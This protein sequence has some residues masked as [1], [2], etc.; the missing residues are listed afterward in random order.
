MV[1]PDTAGAQYNK[2][3]MYYKGDGA[4]QDYTKAA[5]WYRK[6]AEQG[7]ADAQFMLG[8]MYEYGRGLPKD[9]VQAAD[10]Y[11][12]SAEQGNNFAQN[13]LGIMY[14]N[15]RG[16]P[17]NY[18]MAAEWYR[19]SA[20]QGNANAQFKL[21]L[22]YEYGRGLPKDYTKAADWYRKSAEQ[23]NIFAQNNLGVLY[24][25]GDGV[26][27]DYTKAAEWY[28]K[29]A[30]QGNK[31]AQY[32][33]GSMYEEGQGIQKDYRKAAEWYLKA[34]EQGNA[35]AQFKLGLMYGYG[36][37]VPKNYTK[38]AEWYRKSAEQGV[39]EA[40][41]NLALMYCEGRGVPKDEI[42]GLARLYIAVA[43]YNNTNAEKVIRDLEE[44]L[45]D[46]ISLVAQQ[47]SKKILEEIKEAKE[48]VSAGKDN[49]GQPAQ[50]ARGEPQAYGS[51]VLVTSDGFILTAAHVVSGA[52]SVKVV[53]E[54]NLAQPAQVVTVDEANDVA[55]LK[56]EGSFEGAPVEDSGAAGLGKHVFTIGFPSVQVQGCKPKLTS[57]DIS[58]MGG[59]QDD[60][61]QWQ[62]SVPVQ[63]GNSGGPLFDDNGSVIGLIV[64]KLDAIQ[65]AKY[66]GDIPENV[67]Y[68]VK[69]AY[70]MPL[71]KP[72]KNKL[73]QTTQGKTGRTFEEVVHQSQKSAVL[74]LVY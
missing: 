58:S 59:I 42:E 52:T 71:L 13:N 37:G 28:R 9:Y 68:A 62:V 70:F 54:S 60:P 65:I 24:Y 22:M 11:R 72:Y 35:N 8:L 32:M 29:S 31:Y 15:G 12:K 5:E 23:G 20:E 40:Q 46:R 16:L 7:H 30:E 47:R 64:S 49:N 39:A 61:R 21:G 10:W 14:E 45:G 33:L 27:K 67:N 66:T 38:A 2:G 36:R 74:I 17:K 41:N 51:G 56:C 26:P 48:S 19:K 3:L 63:P 73:V 4:P 53:T 44:K 25:R 55:L 6:A 69:S 18:T 1:R 50:I 34:A 57:G 43:A